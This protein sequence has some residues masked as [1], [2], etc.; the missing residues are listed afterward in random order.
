MKLNLKTDV[1]QGVFQVKKKCITK[2]KEQ[3]TNAARPALKQKSNDNG[4]IV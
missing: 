4:W 3:K 1:K 2:E